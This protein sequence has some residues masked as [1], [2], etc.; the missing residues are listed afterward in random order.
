MANVEKPVHRGTEPKQ[1]AFA[2]SKTEFL[3]IVYH[4]FEAIMIGYTA[5]LHVEPIS[6]GGKVRHIGNRELLGEDTFGY[7]FPLAFEKLHQYEDEKRHPRTGVTQALFPPEKIEIPG[8]RLKPESQAVEQLLVKVVVV[9]QGV[10]VIAILRT[11]MPAT[12]E[13]LENL[14]QVWEIA[15]VFDHTIA[16]TA[17]GRASTVIPGNW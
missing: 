10:V 14:I 7:R 15:R 12:A 11:D 17:N 6:L 8:V 13:P 9:I 4:P 5:F 1:A 2:H 3:Q 16:S